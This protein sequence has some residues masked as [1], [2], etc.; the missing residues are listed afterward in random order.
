MY[1]NSKILSKSEFYHEYQDDIQNIM[2][3]IQN[4]VRQ[5]SGTI[6]MKQNLFKTMFDYI[7][8]YS[9]KKPIY[10]GPF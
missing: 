1:R 6:H 2:H 7:Y 3:L 9:D 4:V 5:Q 10:Y 8:L